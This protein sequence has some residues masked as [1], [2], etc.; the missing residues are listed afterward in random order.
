M[1]RRFMKAKIHRATVTQVDLDYVG[2]VTIDRDLL[3]AADIAINEQVDIYN[4]TNGSRITTYA[5]EGPRGSGII[6]VNGPSIFFNSVAR[7][8]S[9]R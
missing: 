8:P 4:I 2:S 3:D 5:I 1:I 7:L 6:G 9:T